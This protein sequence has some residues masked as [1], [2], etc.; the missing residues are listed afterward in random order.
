MCIANC[1]MLTVGFQ[2]LLIELYELFTQVQYEKKCRD[3]W[4]LRQMSR[5][6]TI[7]F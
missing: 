7:V 4:V 2:V 1:S 6:F 5:I 3:S